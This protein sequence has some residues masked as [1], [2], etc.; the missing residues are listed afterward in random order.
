ML[1]AACI[2]CLISGVLQLIAGIKGAKHCQNPDMAHSC[3]I[4]G[5]VVAVFCV[6]GNLFYVIGGKGFD[7][8]SLLT[9][10]LLPAL[11]IYGAVLNKKQEDPM[12]PAI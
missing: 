6:L 4:W 8:T 10:L 2:L 1:Y 3:M 12:E 11:Y 7:V 5:I 9:G